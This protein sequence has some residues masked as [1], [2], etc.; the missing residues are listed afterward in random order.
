M[1]CTLREYQGTK[2]LH[3]LGQITACN[4]KEALERSWAARMPTEGTVLDSMPI[5]TLET[6]Q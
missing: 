2:S 6:Q 5:M 3:V 1:G 4:L